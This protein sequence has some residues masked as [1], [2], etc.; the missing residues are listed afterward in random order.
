MKT[1]LI[2]MTSILIGLSTIS[3]NEE[4]KNNKQNQKTKNGTEISNSLSQKNEDLSLGIE[5]SQNIFLYYRKIKRGLINSNL[6]ETKSVAT[7]FIEKI[8]YSNQAIKTHV[9]N[10]RNSS[11]LEDQR[12]HFNALSVEMEKYLKDSTSKDVIYKQYCPMAFDGKGAFWL[13]QSKEIMNPYFGDKM[14]NCGSIQG[15]IK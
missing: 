2:L 15:T 3:C 4:E 11:T 13:S 14:L 6:E 12:H 8:D 1:H 7:K 10:I 5:D 9:E